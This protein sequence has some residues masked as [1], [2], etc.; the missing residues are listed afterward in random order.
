MEDNPKVEVAGTE[1]PNAQITTTTTTS[2]EVEMTGTQETSVPQTQTQPEADAGERAVQ[3]ESTALATEDTVIEDAPNESAPPAPAPKKSAGFKFLDFLTSPI[4][5]IHVGEGTGAQVLTA[6][7]ALLLDSP[8]L[9]KLVEKFDG[10]SSRR[11]NLPTENVEAFSCF[12]QFEYTRDYSVPQQETPT[13]S[14][15]PEGA[16]PVDR[17]G[18]ELLQHARVYTLAEKL[19]LPALKSL[20]HTK[21][22]RVNGT[23]RGELAYARYVYS[24]TS[25]DDQTIRRPVA[26]YWA[27]RGHVLRHEVG[28]DWDSMCVEV[29]EFTTD[30]LKFLMDRKEK[31]GPAETSES[32]P[33]G[34]KRLR[35]GEK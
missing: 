4:V 35:A 29:P 17:T 23:P 2:N 33:R 21:I 13:G 5:E 10:S 28:G 8:F 20:A 15:E 25:A 19:G 12:L 7:Q 9:A 27:S 26:S 11:I 22:H 30:V 31:S 1:T 14:V 16:A 32:T 24:H 6:H 3:T 34:R 18:E